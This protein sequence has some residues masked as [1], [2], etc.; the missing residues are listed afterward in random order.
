MPEN[1]KPTG[2]WK[3]VIFTPDMPLNLLVNTLNVL[4]QRLA[5]IEDKTMIKIPDENGVEVEMSLTDYYILQAQ[6]EIA[7]MEKGDKK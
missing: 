1:K 6:K 5:A 2:A 3:D 4:N 7:E